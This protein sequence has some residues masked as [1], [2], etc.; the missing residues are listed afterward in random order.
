MCKHARCIRIIEEIDPRLVILN[1]DVNT[2][3]FLP[4]KL[5][6][7]SSSGGCREPGLKRHKEKETANQRSGQQLL[8]KNAD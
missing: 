3:D 6:A 8:R 4:T 7:F 5:C 2:E 1:V